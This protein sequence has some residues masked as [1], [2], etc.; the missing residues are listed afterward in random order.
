M[1]VVSREEAAA[2]AETYAEVLAQETHHTHELVYDEYG[3]LRWK[4]NS[5]VK[6]LFKHGG[7]VN[8]NLFWEQHGKKDEEMKQLYRDMGYSLCGYW[9]IFYWEVNN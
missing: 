6:L 5:S 4:A 1:K 9:E 8:F 2:L 3:T 7:V